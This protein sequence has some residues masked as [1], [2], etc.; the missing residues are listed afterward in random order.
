MAGGNIIGAHHETG[1]V[2]GDNH[3][4]I[5]LRQSTKTPSLIGTRVITI[6][7]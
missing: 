4:R 1:L 3:C 5:Q 2:A 7:K 6:Q